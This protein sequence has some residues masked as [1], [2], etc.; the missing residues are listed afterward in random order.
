M[1]FATRF[2]HPT[3]VRMRFA[4]RFRHP[5]QVRVRFP[6]RPKYECVSPPDPGTIG[7]KTENTFQNQQTVL[8]KCKP[9]TC[10]AGYHRRLNPPTP[11]AREPAPQNA[12]ENASNW[13]CNLPVKLKIR[14]ANSLRIT[15]TG[16]GGFMVCFLD[17]SRSM[18]P[19]LSRSSLTVARHTSRAHHR[20]S[21][22]HS[23]LTRRREAEA[24][25]RA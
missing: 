25:E 22:R 1:R 17:G 18:G 15:A 21:R 5:T 4:T 12:S 7:L 24:R 6:T 11:R 9:V 2:R 10:L 23:R 16:F 20:V 14:Q 13:R 19:S 3:Q 8:T